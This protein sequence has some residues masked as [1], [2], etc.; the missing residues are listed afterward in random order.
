MISL[1]LLYKLDH[2]L[3]REEYINLSICLFAK[4]FEYYV[5][6]ETRLEAPRKRK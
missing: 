2:I 3:K 1:I 5:P 4:V 6:V